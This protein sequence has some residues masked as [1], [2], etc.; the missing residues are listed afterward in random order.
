MT[1]GKDHLFYIYN[2]TLYGLNH[3]EEKAHAFFAGSV[4][5]FVLLNATLL[6]L[7]KGTIYAVAPTGR[8]IEK[9]AENIGS[10]VEIPLT[11]LIRYT[12]EGQADK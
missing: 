10:M 11:Y 2:G 5:E 3:K 8:G 7:D 9:I 1:A 12:G 4:K 6:V